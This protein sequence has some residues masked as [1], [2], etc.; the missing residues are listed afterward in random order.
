M[1][2]TKI[3][4]I[5]I[6]VLLILAAIFLF[7]ACGNKQSDEQVSQSENNNS[8]ENQSAGQPAQDR[9]YGS[10]DTGVALNADMTFTANLYHG[11]VKTGTYTESTGANGFTTVTYTVDGVKYVGSIKDNILTLPA[12]WADSHGHG[13]TFPLQ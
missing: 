12:K 10:G 6:C 9:F 8:G 13:N 11:I 3:I 2:K 1:K 5:L 4:R 7:S